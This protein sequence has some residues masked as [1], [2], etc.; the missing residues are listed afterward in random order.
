MYR[1]KK[2]TTNET[3]LSENKTLTIFIIDELFNKGDTAIADKYF[4]PDFAKEE[5]EFMLLIRKAFP[6]LV[7]KIEE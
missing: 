2:A 4:A 7:I 3:I 6:D 1:T 5:K